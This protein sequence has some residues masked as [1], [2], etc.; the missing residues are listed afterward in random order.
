VLRIFLPSCNFQ[1]IIQFFGAVNSY[2][3]ESDDGK[4][5]LQFSKGES[6]LEVN[7]YQL[8]LSDY[9]DNS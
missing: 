4:M 8:G 2:M 3:A 1:E 9:A 5:L 6:W 7:E